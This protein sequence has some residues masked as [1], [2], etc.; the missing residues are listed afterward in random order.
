V[1]LIPAFILLTPA[2]T[3]GWQITVQTDRSYYHAEDIVYINGT[4]TYMNGPRQSV[5]VGISVTGPSGS[6]DQYYYGSPTTDTNGKY[7]AHFTLRYNAELG[8]Y[9]VHANAEG[10]QSQT[11]FQINDT[12]YIKSDGGIEP[13][14][15]PISRNGFLYT[16]ASNIVAN[17]TNG[18]VIE[19]NDIILNGVGFALNGK[20]LANSNGIYLARVSNVTIENISIDSFLDGVNQ[21]YCPG[22]HIVDTDL[23]SNGNGIYYQQASSSTIEGNNI[24]KNSYAGILLDGSYDNNISANSLTNTIASNF[25]A[26]SLRGS[27]Y[28]NNIVN[29]NFANNT[30][31]GV[32]IEASYSNSIFHNNFFNN[33]RQGFVTPDSSGNLWDNG[34]PSGG[35]FWSDYKGIDVKSG[36]HQ[37]QPGS[38]GMGDAPYTINANNKDLYPLMSAWVPTQTTVTATNG[39]EYPVTIT[40]A[41]ATITQINSTPNNLNFTVTG[42]PNTNGSLLIIVPK[43]LNT[44]ALKV[45]VNGTALTNPAPTIIDN[46]THYFIYC[47]LTFHSTFQILVPFV[48]PMIPMGTL[49]ATVSMISVL[50][51]Y[52]K[53]RRKKNPS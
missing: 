10:V 22:C 19:R 32:Y 2:H 7:N 45:T 17:S 53:L 3:G 38:D 42:T 1:I 14:N 46:R 6:G 26:I 44:T 50:G 39:T 30:L 34:Y 18:I 9:M 27:S 41:N 51:V 8:T 21:Y 20:G 52:I 24:T 37:D 4:L 48:V 40:T 36:P 43:G 47:T 35:N 11:T 12:I 5:E 13:A 25:G 49:T 15:A 28:D 29:N 23:F 31:Y 33:T 16:L